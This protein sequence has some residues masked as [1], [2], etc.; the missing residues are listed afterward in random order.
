MTSNKNFEFDGH[1]PRVTSA[2]YKRI[3]KNMAQGLV[4]AMLG[5]CAIV[6]PAQASAEQVALRDFF[7][8]RQFINMKLSPDARHIAFSYEQGNEVRLAV[9]TAA[10]RK[11]VNHFSFGDAM[12]VQ[13]FIWATNQRLVMAVGKVTGYLDSDGRPTNLYASDIN[14]D[15]RREIFEMASSRYALL[16]RLPKDPAHILIAKYHW[17]D[18]GKGKV[19]RLN[20]ENGRL[21]YTADEPSGDIRGLGADTEGRVRIAVETLEGKSEDLSLIHI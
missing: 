14:G 5:F 18:N 9:M 8:R 15:N 13:E 4:C 6:L 16:H 10:D 7:E 2:L 19:H 20:I 21:D 17:A 3:C 12:H 1:A 11:V